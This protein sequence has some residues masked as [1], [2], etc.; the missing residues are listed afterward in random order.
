MKRAADFADLFLITA[1]TALVAV[2]A[3]FVSPAGPWLVVGSVC[4]AIGAA[5]LFHNIRSRR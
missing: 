1:G 4:L 2:G 5:I 3:S